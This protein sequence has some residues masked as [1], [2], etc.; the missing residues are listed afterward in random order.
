MGD[1][2]M[3]NEKCPKCG[4]M[5]TVEVY[6]APSSLIWSKHCWKCRWTDGLGYYEAPDN[7]VVLCTEKQARKKKLIMKCPKCKQTMTWWEKM[8]YGQCWHCEKVGDSH[9]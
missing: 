5:N 4:G 6:D 8:A 1:R 3:W 7:E 2:T 9:R